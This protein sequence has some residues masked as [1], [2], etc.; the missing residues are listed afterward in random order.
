MI[1]DDAGLWCMAA[2][3][4][5]VSIIDVDDSFVVL[6]LMALDL[7]DATASASLN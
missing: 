3:F 2:T 5:L 7:N 1:K 4:V 6:T